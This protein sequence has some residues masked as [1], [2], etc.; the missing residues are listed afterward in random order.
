MK[1]VTWN[2]FKK[3]GSIGYYLLTKQLEQTEEEWSWW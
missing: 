1:E 2:L 3:T